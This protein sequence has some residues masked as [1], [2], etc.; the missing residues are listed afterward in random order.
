MKTRNILIYLMLGV[1]LI[2]SAS[3]ESQAVQGGFVYTLSNFTGPIPYNHSRLAVDPERNEVYV[4]FQNAVR[5]FNESGM[6]VYRFG[7]DL[8]LGAIVDV[9]VDQGGDILLLAYRD[10]RWEIVRCNYRGEL[11][12]TLPLKNLP[13]GFSDFSPNRMVYR[14][15]SL[16]LASTTGLKAVIADRE[17]TVKKGFDLFSLFELEEKDRGNVDLVGFNVDRDGNILMTVPVQFRAYVLSPEGKIASFGKAGSGPGRF[18]IVAGIARDSRGNYLVVDKLK[19]AVIVFDKRFNFLTDFGYP[20]R[21][22][23][24]LVYPEEVVVDGSDRLFVTQMG[25]RGV[26]VFRLAY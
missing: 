19:S 6:E 5:V 1:L 13:G 12:S 11:K 24:N 26:S 9:A 3:E 15:G 22:P 20:G 8:D 16:Y 7:D 23:G 14:D 21:K 10:T 25:K 4:L 18:N 17:G 2:C